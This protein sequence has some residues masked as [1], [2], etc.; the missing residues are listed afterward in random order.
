MNGQLPLPSSVGAEPGIVTHRS[1][2]LF[3]QF[4]HLEMYDLVPKIPGAAD[5]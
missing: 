4:V 5:D 1:D 2:G 3:G